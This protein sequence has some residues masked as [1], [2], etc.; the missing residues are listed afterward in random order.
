METYDFTLQQWMF[1]NNTSPF[2]NQRKLAKNVIRYY[3]EVL[4]KTPESTYVTNNSGNKSI[5]Y[6]FTEEDEKYIYHVYINLLQI[7]I[8]TQLLNTHALLV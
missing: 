7:E 1:K 8:S 5:N 6:V 3:K 4:H 2:V